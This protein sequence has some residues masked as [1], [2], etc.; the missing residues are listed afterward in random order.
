M[1]RPQLQRRELVD[2]FLDQWPDKEFT[3]ND[4][5]EFAGITPADASR[6]LQEHRR[7]QRAFGTVSANG[8][9][10]EKG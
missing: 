2:A 7:R 1:S 6:L 3:R 8:N 5:A 10:K 4:L 9:G